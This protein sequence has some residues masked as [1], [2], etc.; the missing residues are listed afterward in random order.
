MKLI[1]TL[2][3]TATV[4]ALNCICSLAPMLMRPAHASTLINGGFETGDLT[5]WS[6][7]GNVFV[8]D[9]TINPCCVA[10]EGDFFADFNGAD[11]AVN[12]QLS[13]T[14][15]TTPGSEYILSFDFAKGG[16]FPGTAALSIE[17]MSLGS[18][19]NEMVS[20]SI[21]GEPG[22]YSNFFFFFTA[23]SASATLTFNDISDGTFRFDALI[24]DIAVDEVQ[25]VP[26]SNSL[27]GLLVIGT[28]GTSRM[29]IRKRSGC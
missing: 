15:L 6:A 14:F 8:G 11:T 3:L 4:L 1:Y 7:S 16:T 9:S 19:L 22:A 21:G 20:D 25:S 18:L 24:D 26:E 12:G 10:S 17:V 29:L 2:N 23:D 27:L 13:Q 5:G 28:L